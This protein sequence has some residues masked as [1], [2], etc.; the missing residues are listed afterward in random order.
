VT[1]VGDIVMSLGDIF[2]YFSELSSQ[3]RFYIRVKTRRQGT[4]N[5]TAFVYITTVQLSIC[6]SLSLSYTHT[7]CF[8]LSTNT[9]RQHNHGYYAIS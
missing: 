2:M 8:I 1:E 3:T 7:E 6:L 4:H 5:T 9:L